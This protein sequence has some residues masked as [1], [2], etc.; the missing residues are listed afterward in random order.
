M[1]A[2][3]LAKSRTCCLRKP[4][5]AALVVLLLGLA[6]VAIEAG[7]AVKVAADHAQK[8]SKGLELFKSDV[9]AVFTQHCIKCHGGEKT[10]GELDLTTREGL[11]KGGSQG[12]TIEVGRSTESLLYQLISH[13]EEPNMPEEAPKLPATAIASIGRW[14][15]LGAPYDKPLIEDD[16]LTHG[17]QIT[18]EQ[19]SF[20]SFRPLAEPQVPA[21]RDDAA[22]C[23][24]AVDRLRLRPPSGNVGSAQRTSICVQN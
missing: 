13:N 2:C 3:R 18:P 4:V 14:I 1:K 24:S 20:W 12:P 7:E 19:R 5:S 15:D 17:G 8:M 21:V 16:P 10:N 23:R 6:P 22:W 9:R 11:L